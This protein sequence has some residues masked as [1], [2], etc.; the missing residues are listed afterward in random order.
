MSPTA[1]SNCWP[2]T[3]LTKPAACSPRFVGGINV[4]NG[5]VTCREVAA[6]HGLPFNAVAF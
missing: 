4:M 3:V 2:T 6:A 1:M 5:G